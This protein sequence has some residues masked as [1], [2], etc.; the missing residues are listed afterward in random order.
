MDAFFASV[1]QLDNPQLRGKPVVVGGSGPRGVVAAA[2][3]EVREFGVRSAMPMREALRRCPHLI[4]VR[5]RM[6]RYSQVSAQVFE[7]FA[8]YT[9]IIQGLSL[10]E[11]YLD[12]TETQTLM[13]DVEQIGRRIKAAIRDCTQLTASVGIG[14]NKLLAKIASDMDKPDGFFHI[15]AEQ[16][17]EILDPLP[18]RTIGGIGP[19]TAKRLN[20]ARIHTLGELRMASPSH[21]QPIF[22]R[23]TARMQQRAAGID[24]RPVQSLVDDKSISAEET[25]DTDLTDRAQISSAL[26]GLADMVAERVR[27]KSLVAGVVRVKIRRADFSTYT[28]QKR[29]SPPTDETRVI[30]EIS[31]ALLNDWLA[32]FPGAAVRLLGVGVASLQTSSQL[33]LFETTPHD[34]LDTALDN[35]RKRFGQGSMKRGGKLRRD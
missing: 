31:K 25:Y 33:G 17:I 4:A 6:Q 11:A 18:V 21:L 34:P 16:A 28:R 26:V 32:E 29:V 5:S 24:D 9:P 12:V 20:R 10:D 27:K 23:Y 35:I 15:H 2:S 30:S 3:Y 13:G 7:V 22:G 1:E 14:P 19:Q 8:N